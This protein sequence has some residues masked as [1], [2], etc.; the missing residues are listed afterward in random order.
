MERGLDDLGLG[1]A[2]RA[3]VLEADRRLK[4]MFPV[5]RTVIFGSVARGQAGEESDLDLLVVTT[6]PPTHRMRNAMSDE[7]FAI[8]LEHGTNLSI[9]VV[10]AHSW[11]R[12]PL[13]H[14]PLHAE[15]A[16]DG[17]LL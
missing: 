4:A 11:E 16:R 15:I 1:E 8:N 10:E 7:I 13:A 14:T 12:G 6:E 5:A 2:E 17:V 3:A 9:V